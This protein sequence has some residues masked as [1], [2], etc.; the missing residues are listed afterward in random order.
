[1]DAVIVVPWLLLLHFV[2]VVWVDSPIDG[3]ALSGIWCS[4]GC[5]EYGPVALDSL[6]N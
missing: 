6:V 4:L 3:D 1:M 2:W 5:R